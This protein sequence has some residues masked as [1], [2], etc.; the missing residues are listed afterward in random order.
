[1][2]NAVSPEP[3]FRPATNADAESVRS[4]VFGALDEYRLAADPDETDRDLFDIEASYAAR[5]GCFEVLV[6]EAD[7]II[8]SYGLYPLRED[9][10]E[11][12]KMYLDR[13]CRGHGLG[14]A[15][16]KRAL[17]Q[18]RSL[19]FRRVELETAAVLVEA[20]ALYRSFGFRPFTPDHMSCRCDQ[21][22]F[23]ELAAAPPRIIET[24]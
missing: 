3:R 22:M 24:P 10:C 5:G 2:K 19:G 12:R 21:A 1:M 6:D 16:M 23:L 13:S 14:K 20:I 8:G 11:L 7:R 15:I 9:T 18:A 4:L 17:Q